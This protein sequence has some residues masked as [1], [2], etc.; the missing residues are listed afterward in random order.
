MRAAPVVSLL[1]SRLRPYRRRMPVARAAAGGL[2]LPFALLALV[3]VPHGQVITPLPAGPVAITAIAVGL[4]PSDSSHDRVSRFVY[5]GG[6]AIDAPGRFGGLSDIDVLPDGRA[7]L[8]ADEGQMLDMRIVLD[9]SGRLS[10][11]TDLR[12][13]PLTGLDGR[14]LTDKAWADSEGVA[15]LANGDRL[16]SFERQHRIW[17]YPAG[18]GPPV[19]AP[20]PTGAAS[21]PLNAGL[22]ALAALPAT[23]SSWPAG[24]YLAGS[25]GGIVWLCELAGGCRQTALGSRVPEGFGLTGIAVCPDGQTL[26]LLTRAYDQERGVRVRVRLVGREAIDSAEAPQ[27]DELVLDEP[28]TRDNFE[29]LAIVKGRAPGTLRLY[30]LSDNNFSAT[31]RT[32]LLA[33]DWMR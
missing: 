12:R 27:L 4:N 20:A 15:V 19:A 13:S 32:Y 10:G 21:F 28:L 23:T 5:A 11:I 24:S 8:V 25:E 7:V 3:H 18:G 9:A 2:L 14:A 16:V 17:R 6:V 33:F 26:A 30:L 29:G 1:F 22:E 31:Q